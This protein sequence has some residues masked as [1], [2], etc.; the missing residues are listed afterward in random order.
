MKMWWKFAAPTRLSRAEWRKN[1]NKFHSNSI[2]RS[3]LNF[4]T[5]PPHP[6]TIRSPQ[7]EKFESVAIIDNISQADNF[8]IFHIFSSFSSWVWIN[9]K[10]GRNDT[11][12][13]RTEVNWNE[14]KKW[15]KHSRR[16]FAI[17][18]FHNNFHF[19][20]S[21]WVFSYVTCANTSQTQRCIFKDHEKRDRDSREKLWNEHC[22]HESL[23]RRR[24]KLWLNSPEVPSFVPPSS[25]RSRMFRWPYRSPDWGVHRA[26]CFGG[27]RGEHLE[28][29]QK[30]FHN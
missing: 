3:L 9:A 7:N 24:R 11:F 21:R 16:I 19:S 26:P 13:S 2:I 28:M 12:V 22:E 18:N 25:I 1:E 15:K 29:S 6:V 23:R 14:A 5:T 8:S 4:L 20:F 30:K 27:Q 17:T 10:H